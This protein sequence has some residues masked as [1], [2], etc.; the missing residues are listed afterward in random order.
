MEE[1]NNIV[2]LIDDSMANGWKGI[3]FERLQKSVSANAKRGR[4]DWID[5]I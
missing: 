2:E 1:N 4:L 5:D 3:I